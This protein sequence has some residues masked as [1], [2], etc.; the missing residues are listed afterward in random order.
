MASVHAPPGGSLV[1]R[2]QRLWPLPHVRGDAGVILTEPRRS[3][4]LLY[5]C[6]TAVLL[7]CVNAAL[8]GHPTWSQGHIHTSTMLGRRISVVV[9]MSHVIGNAL[10][11]FPMRITQLHLVSCSTAVQQVQQQYSRFAVLV[12]QYSQYSCRRLCQRRVYCSTAVQ[13]STAVQQ[14]S[15][16]TAVQQTAG[17]QRRF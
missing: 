3:A 16:S 6:C 4:V 9:I 15:S 7:Y 5:C 14:Y 2:V 8:V 13:H 11:W 17:A 1:A 12:Q 10:E